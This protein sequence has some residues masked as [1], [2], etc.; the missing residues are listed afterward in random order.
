MDIPLELAF[1]NMAPSEALKAAVEREVARLERFFNHIIGCRVVIEMPHKRHRLGNNAPDVH[2]LL[3]VPGREIVVTRELARAGAKKSAVN[4]YAVLKDAF[5]AVQQRL[6]D[7]RRQM[8]GEIKPK[9]APLF[10][11]VAE[12]MAERKYGF[13]ATEGGS[14]IYFHRNSVAGDGFDRLRIGDAVEYA[15]ALSDKGEAAARVWLSGG[16]NQQDDLFSQ[17]RQAAE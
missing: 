16:R 17:N 4:A 3:R 14:Q 10:G 15:P 9:D 6:K 1:H 7:Y 11:H 12:L 5:Q 13:I 2:V 8:Q